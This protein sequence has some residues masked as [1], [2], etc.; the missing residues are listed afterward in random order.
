MCQ[1]SSTSPSTMNKSSMIFES[2][3]QT[4]MPTYLRIR[5]GRRSVASRT[6]LTPP[7][8]ASNLGLKTVNS[9]ISMENARN[10]RCSNDTHKCESLDWQKNEHHMDNSTPNSIDRHHHNSSCV[11]SINHHCRSNN[12]EMDEIK[13]NTKHTH[14]TNTMPIGSRKSQSHMKYNVTDLHR[15]HKRAVNTSKLYTNTHTE[16]QRH[17]RTYRE[18]EPPQWWNQ[19]N[20][21]WLLIKI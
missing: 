1:K 13:Q 5:M 6:W 21:L 2:R 4:V 16:R 15:T 7:D 10:D 8:F 12:N 17:R 19:H 20:S 14:S 11:L 9:L 18:L 3:S